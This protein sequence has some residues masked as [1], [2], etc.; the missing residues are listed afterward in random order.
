MNRAELIETAAAA[1]R[2]GWVDTVDDL[3]AL[4]LAADPSD[5]ELLLLRARSAVT[6]ADHAGAVHWFGRALEASGGQIAVALE[7]LP[8]VHQSG[9]RAEALELARELA[10]AIPAEHADIRRDLVRFVSDRIGDSHAGAALAVVDPEHRALMPIRLRLESASVCNLR[11]QHC[12]TGVHYEA[13][14]RSVMKRDLFERVIDQMRAMPSLK[15]CVLYLGGEP[16]MNK[17]L[18]D[19]CR[20]VKAQTSVERTFITT[21]GMLLNDS[22]CRALAA[23]N[24][25]QIFVSVDGRSPAENDDIR[26]RASYEVIVAN[27]ARLR[28]YLEGTGTQIVISHAMI[29]RPGDPEVPVTPE[30]LRRDFPGIGVWSDYATRWPGFELDRTGLEAA[31]L[32]VGSRTNFC[33]FPFAEMSVRVT[34]DVVLCCHDL[35]GESV[36]G[37]IWKST[38]AEIWNGPAYRELRRHMLARNPQGVHEVCRRCFVFTGERIER[39]PLS[40][41]QCA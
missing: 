21:N 41:M 8:V 24:L 14:E 7:M 32:Q 23:A 11:C 3:C 15:E 35:L 2:A 20:R 18:P 22:N 40:E 1:L 13:T 10:A 6:R 36:V 4:G 37:N 5:L 29:R 34:G 9:A 38:L 28:R 19:M 17:H 30:F 31:S 25:D 33:A 27:V 39:S 26:V 16:L 12:P